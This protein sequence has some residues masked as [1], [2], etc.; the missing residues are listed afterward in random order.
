MVHLLN[1]K[2]LSRPIRSRSRMRPVVHLL[3]PIQNPL[4]PQLAEALEH[5]MNTLSVSVTMASPNLSSRV[6][7]RAS[8]DT[9]QML[10]YNPNAPRKL[11]KNNQTSETPPPTVTLAA[12]TARTINTISDLLKRPIP[13][14]DPQISNS[15]G[16]LNFLY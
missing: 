5:K 4:L 3:K 11:K 2:I 7:V 9:Q 15:Y 14:S 10:R 12:S 16:M 13:G 1:P 8:W 6:G